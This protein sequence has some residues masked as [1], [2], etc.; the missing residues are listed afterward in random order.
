MFKIN[1]GLEFFS[2]KDKLHTR[3][4]THQ[5]HDCVVNLAGDHHFP[6]TANRKI[7]I[8]LDN[9]FMADVSKPIRHAVRIILMYVGVP[10]S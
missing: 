4:L 10:L 2:L 8:Y 5:N 1:I 9:L 3:Y 7:V 6:M